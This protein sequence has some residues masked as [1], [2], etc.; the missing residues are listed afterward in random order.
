MGNV[1]VFV[2]I[3]ILLFI[4]FVFSYK[5]L[6][7][8]I[9]HGTLIAVL[10]LLFQILIFRYRKRVHFSEPLWH[11]AGI[12]SGAYIL[13]LILI[14]YF[15]IPIE[16]LHVDRWSV[17]SSF[18]SELNSGNYPYYAKSHLGNY[19]G[20]MPIY[21]LIALPFYWLGELSLLSGLGYFIM[22]FLFFKKECKKEENFLFIYLIGSLFVIWEIATRSNVF[23]FSILVML[24]LERF[25]N[26]KDEKAFNF[27]LT[28][29]LMGVMLST[30]SVFILSY[31][32]FFLS[33]FIKKEWT[34]RR[35]FVFVLVAK[36]SFIVT[37]VPFIIFYDNDFF[38]MNPFII[39]SSFLIPRMYTIF[40]MLLAF[41]L[42][43]EVK[44]KQEKYFYSGVSLF[45]AILLY[46]VYHVIQ[47]GLEVAYI[48]SKID[49]SYFIF[50]IPFLMKY[51]LDV[52][53][54]GTVQAST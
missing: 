42:S 43:F 52:N 9:E 44:T 19:P 11:I 41:F 51:I 36:L 30:R 54:K 21:F 6:P 48:N 20:P 26:L 4:N 15:F 18:M 16:S 29:I 46:A 32:I 37:F 17:I 7:R 53:V 45:I 49:V 8:Y 39:Q 31:I 1:K 40:F 34:F 33:N 47:D 25:T 10:L 23:T 3:V 38:A 27:Y 50:C 13:G 24:V 22:L 5:Y 28:A 12:F 14:S 35:L 2:S